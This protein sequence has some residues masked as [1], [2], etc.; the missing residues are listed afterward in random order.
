MY[1]MIIAD[2][3]A[4]LRNALVETVDWESIGFTVVG[5]AENGIEALELVEKL[6]PDLLLTDIKMPF[7]SGIDLARSAREISPAMNIAFISGFDDFEYAK[8][9]IQYNIISYILKPVSASELRDEM[10]AI[11]DK[12][13]ARVNALRHYRSPQDFDK[14]NAE[15]QSKLFL[16]S[17]L[18]EDNN[19]L[20]KRALANGLK[21]NDNEPTR[22][23][24][25][26]VNVYD[27]SGKNVTDE[28]YITLVDSILGKYVRSIS[29]F[30]NNSIITI[31]SEMEREI[32]RYMTLFPKE[33]CQ[34]VDKIFGYDTK[35]GVSNIYGDLSRTRLAYYEA[36]DAHD[37]ME[38][39]KNGIIYISDHER[40]VAEKQIH[41]TDTIDN[42]L[43]ILKTEDE[44]H[45]NSFI[46]RI[47]RDGELDHGLLGSELM[48]AIY[49]T[50][51]SYAGKEEAE[52]IVDNMFRRDEQMSR[53]MKKRSREELKEFAAMARRV[54]VE[55]R[56]SNSQA[57]CEE[58]D[59]II[60][61]E[62]G[63]ETLSLTVISERLH[64][65][66]N[67]LS[68]LIKKGKG[69]SF[70]NLLTAKRMQV[71]KEAIVYSTK[72]ILEIALECGFSDNHYFSYS[73]KK[74]YGVSPKKMREDLKKENG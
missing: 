64:L 49:E 58:V 20:D 13:D 62:F 73:F 27:D 16:Y 30:T 19:N 57:I 68:G 45:I 15:Y 72:K 59:R 38:H 28:R 36:V 2:D 71:A 24:I 17:M 4:E 56:K 29:I 10:L 74:Y 60:D 25:Q 12:M 18:M 14:L 23:I 48:V 44:E 66:P 46:D 22:Y 37:Y 67:Y 1:T 65:T 69:E 33:I 31:A 26:M 40:K 21:K 3:E 5:E 61:N 53:L 70:I 11:K 32:K 43:R 7:L 41:V 54:I 47:Y 51:K 55:Q 9:A 8:Q 50:I 34:T 39:E 6:N 35:V 63:D 42:L 52:K